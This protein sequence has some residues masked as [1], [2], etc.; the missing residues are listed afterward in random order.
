MAVAFGRARSRQRS[1]TT[2]AGALLFIG[3]WP[4]HTLEQLGVKLCNDKGS[5][6]FDRGERTINSG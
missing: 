1:Q 3:E 5:E 6:A 2:V 4:P